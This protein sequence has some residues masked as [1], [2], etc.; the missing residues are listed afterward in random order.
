MSTPRKT[1]VSG[2]IRPRWP[3]ARVLKW[4]EWG[5]I[6]AI[7]GLWLP[8][9][10]GGYA[11]AFT[12]APPGPGALPF[13]PVVTYAGAVILFVGCLEGIRDMGVH[14][15]L[16]RALAILAVLS[17]AASIPLHF[18]AAGPGPVFAAELL[19]IGLAAAL[20]TA[21][22]GITIAKVAEIATE[23]RARRTRD[24]VVA[25]G[26]SA[27]AAGVA[28][29]ALVVAGSPGWPIALRLCVVLF[30]AAFVACRYGVYCYRA[31]TSIGAAFAAA[32]D[33][34]FWV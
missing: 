18:L 32:P 29:A 28:S 24:A 1:V 34:Q 12:G 5:A 26:A 27:T 2:S 7:L 6:P 23:T 9:W 30:T 31:Q 4:L 15:R 16:A 8:D 21:V 20:G 25:L 22:L 19:S 3:K 10:A 33:E 17:A 14:Y 11:A 13:P